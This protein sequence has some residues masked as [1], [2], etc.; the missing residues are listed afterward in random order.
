MQS[1]QAER[2]GA[3]VLKHLQQQLWNSVAIENV[4]KM[5]GPFLAKDSQEMLKDFVSMQTKPYHLKKE[6]IRK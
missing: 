1:E 5:R 2:V 3:H 4:K 6:K